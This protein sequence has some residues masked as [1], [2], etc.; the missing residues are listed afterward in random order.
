MK[1]LFAVLTCLAL[2]LANAQ[3]FTPISV[4]KLEQ[5]TEARNDTIYVFNFWATW[6]KPCIEEMPYFEQLQEKYAD[7]PLRVIFV[8]VDINEHVDSR[9][10]P[11]LKKKKLKCS[12]FQINEGKP[13]NWIDR[14]DP[15][16]SLIHI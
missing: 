7:Q 8:S 10:K 9:L 13:N 11:F 16:L 5:F 4:D 14:I 2:S 15:S 1:I 12:V 3:N 6:C